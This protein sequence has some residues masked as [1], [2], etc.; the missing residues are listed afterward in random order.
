M[1]FEPATLNFAPA[2]PFFRIFLNL[3][4]ITDNLKLFAQAV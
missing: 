4:L 2:I 1:S 3:E